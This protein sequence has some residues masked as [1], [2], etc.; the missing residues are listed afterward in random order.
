MSYNEGFSR[1]NVCKLEEKLDVCLWVGSFTL[2]LKREEAGIKV[3]A[4]GLIN[5]WT[6]MKISILVK[7]G[8]FVLQRPVGDKKGFVNGSVMDLLWFLSMLH[9]KLKLCYCWP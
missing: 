4:K 5:S 8:C 1:I 6:K 2:T 3:N 9:S 7:V